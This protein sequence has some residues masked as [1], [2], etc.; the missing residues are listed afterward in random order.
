VNELLIGRVMTLLEPQPGE[1]V[2]D[3]YAGL[4]NFTLPMARRGAEVFA[5]EGEP[6]LVEQLNRNVEANGLTG[7]QAAVA[8]LGAPSSNWSW[9]LPA[10]AK[11]L[12]DPPRSG[13]EALI[14]ALG[15]LRPQRVV[16]VSCNPKTLARDVGALCRRWHF[17]LTDAGVVDMFPH[18]SHMESIAVL[19]PGS[20]FEP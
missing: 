16:Y 10:P 15:R 1:R 12:L 17:R 8:D 5:V 3:L 20:E 14:D 19:E 2:L 9:W 4:G 7:V 6:A 11:V 13:A 18:T